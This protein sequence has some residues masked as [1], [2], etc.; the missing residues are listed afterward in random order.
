MKADNIN[1]RGFITAGDR[2]FTIPVYQRNYEWKDS[3][4]SKLFS[5]IE[6]VASG[7]S[8]HFVGTIVYVTSDANPTWSEYTVIDGQQ[9]ITT[10]M[11]LLKAIHDLSEDERIKR[12]IWNTY[13]TNEYASEEKY[14]LK[15]KPIESDYI[16]WSK[17]IEG[18]IP[19]NISSN[20][21]KNYELFKHKIQNSSFSLQEIFDAVGKLEIVYIQLEVGKENP[22]IIFESINSTGLSLTQ[23]DL[24]RNFLLMNCESTEKQ[25]RLY[26]EYWVKIENYLTPQVVPDFFRDYLS[27]KMSSIANKNT[28]YETFKTHFR[29][30]DSVTEEDSLNELCRYARYYNWFRL[31][32]SDDANLNFLLKQFHEIKS[33][34]AFGVMLWLFDKCYH[35]NKMTIPQLCDTLKTL[36]CFQF[37]RAICK[38]P[39]NALNKIYMVLSKE[40]G[41]STDIPK[42]LLDVLTKKVKTQ[43]FP[44]NDEFR[45]AFVSFDLY[46]AKLAKYTLAMLENKLNPR[47][48]VSLTSQISIEHIMPQTLTPTWKAELGEHFE[49]I[50]ARWLHTVGNLTFS[51]FNSELSNK[52]FS[53]KKEKFSQSNFSLSKEV[54]HSTNWQETDIEERANKLAEM[55]L[56]IWSLP[57]EYNRTSDKAEI[58][59]SATYCIMDDVII[60]DEKPRSYIF[61]DNEKSID[62]WKALFLGVLKDLYE[63]EPVIFNKLT[64]NETFK[65]RHLAEPADSGY[66]YRS[67]SVDEICPGYYAETGHS[68]QDLVTFT[69]IA[70]EIYDLQ[71]EIYFTLRRKTSNQHIMQSENDDDS[72]FDES[73]GNQND[74]YVNRCILTLERFYDIE[75]V[76]NGRS[77]YTTPDNEKGFIIRTSKA[78]EQGG[79]NKYWFAYKRPAL[80]NIEHCRSKYVV[81][82]CKDEDILVC[83]PVED[84]ENRLDN[85]NTS[86]NSDGSI[87][88]WHIVILNDT[89]NNIT[90]LLSKPIIQEISMN[91]YVLSSEFQQE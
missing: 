68:A 38:A 60:T 31:S 67:R 79:R 66:Q 69:Q 56:Q 37:R 53:E 1:F 36:L 59:Y 87:S 46:S 49:Q 71:D 19:D 12:Q 89:N 41:D 29:N 45:A 32:N 5:D 13:L 10:V 25:T 57:E 52:S 39:T 9:R 34:A 4:C 22:Q 8:S 17:V 90:L 54:A 11:L 80:A 42:K 55:A 33:T 77:A 21:W 58:D 43:S 64:E 86:T 76:K 51:G 78:Y 65:K 48:Q 30:D 84:I 91:E 88:H 73:D 47:E 35:E 63:F 40:I 74:D 62:S 61:G 50:H 28:V 81:Y 44:R 14:R 27:M 7:N 26:K 75:L 20:I 15:L 70:A 2:T 72:T 83:L 24:I 18:H 85:L 6:M 82:A 3:E 23:G 16:T